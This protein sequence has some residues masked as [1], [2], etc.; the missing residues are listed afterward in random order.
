MKNSQP[1]VNWVKLLVPVKAVEELKIPSPSNFTHNESSQ[2]LNEALNYIENHLSI[3]NIKR[4]LIQAFTFRETNSSEVIKLIKTLN[5]NKTCHNTD[6]LQRLLRQILI[7]LS[8]L[9]LEITIIFLKKVN[10][11]VCLEMLILYLYIRKNKKPIK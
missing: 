6:I 1:I 9:Y 3:V 11:L 10:F 5:I 2:S 8:V 4:V 7:S